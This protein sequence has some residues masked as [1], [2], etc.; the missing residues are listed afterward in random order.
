MGMYQNVFQSEIIALMECVQ[1]N[2]KL[3]YKDKEIR[4]YT[5]QSDGFESES[6]KVGL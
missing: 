1:G 3:G 5:G 4:I 2:V 6:V